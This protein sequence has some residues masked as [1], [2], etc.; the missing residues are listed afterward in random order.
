MNEFMLIIK[1]IILFVKLLKT[2]SR[3]N[4]NKH[5]VRSEQYACFIDILL[6]VLINSLVF[7]LPYGGLPFR[8]AE[9]LK[10]NPPRGIN[11]VP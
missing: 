11:D 1:L 4:E 9:T 5:T 10:W 3:Q 7:I 6:G 8:Q 2:I